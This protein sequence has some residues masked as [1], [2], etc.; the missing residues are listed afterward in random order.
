MIL[1]LCPVIELAG[2]QVQKLLDCMGMTKYQRSFR[3]ACVDGKLLAEC[4]DT[5]LHEV[6]MVTAR[7]PLYSGNHWSVLSTQIAHL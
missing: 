2:P 3:D 1:D 7:V 6:I 5:V 4:D